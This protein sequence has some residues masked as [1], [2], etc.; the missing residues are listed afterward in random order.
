MPVSLEEV[1]AKVAKR[2][3]PLAEAKKIGLVKELEP[4]IVQG[5]EV[6]LDKIIGILIDNAIKY[7]PTDTTITLRT[8]LQDGHGY[9]E[10]RDQGIGIKAT[11]L[12]HIFDRFYRADSSRSKLHVAGHGLG[13][14]IAQKLAEAL[15]AQIEATSA[16]SK[17]SV[18]VLKL[19]VVSV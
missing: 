12:P 9:L 1:A 14:S 16:P 18:F 8:Y 10:V 11:E 5:N 4:V 6:A 19:P 15:G 7:S 3:Q 13:L 17:G 2:M